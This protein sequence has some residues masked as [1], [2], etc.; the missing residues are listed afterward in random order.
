LGAL[1]ATAAAL[2]ALIPDRP[3]VS[4][5][6]AQPLDR[7][8]LDPLGAAQPAGGPHRPH[9]AAPRW[10]VEALEHR[11]HLLGAGLA[12]QAGS[13]GGAAYISAW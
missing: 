12:F 6:A 5:L 13:G 10:P 3:W 11:P 7:L 8:D 9:S 1:V 4:S 2:D